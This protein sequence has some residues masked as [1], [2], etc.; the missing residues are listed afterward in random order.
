[1]V[2]VCSVFAFAE[3]VKT[4]DP[5]NASNDQGGCAE[6]EAWSAHG[7]V[8]GSAHKEEETQSRHAKEMKKFIFCTGGICQFLRFLEWPV[9]AKF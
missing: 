3:L 9:K 8:N 1:L 7:K 2:E 6:P 5:Q 4:A